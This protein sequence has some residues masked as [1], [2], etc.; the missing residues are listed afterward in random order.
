MKRG[1]KQINLATIGFDAPGGR[2]HEFGPQSG[3]TFRE[4]YLRPALK[5]HEHVVLLFDGS[6]GG[7][8]SFHDEAIGGLVRDS[9]LTVEEAKTRIEIK[10]SD[11]E[12]GYV[13]DLVRRVIEAA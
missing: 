3:E 11:P 13:A 6:T 4:K 8:S 7:T 10:A 5:S 12:L 1:I 9:T 2:T